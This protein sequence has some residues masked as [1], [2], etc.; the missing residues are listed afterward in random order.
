MHKINSLIHFSSPY[1]FIS[2]SYE[3]NSNNDSLCRIL[4]FELAKHNIG[5]ITAGG[6]PGLQVIDSMDKTYLT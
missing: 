5:I 6:K 1:V 3:R 2:G 4:G